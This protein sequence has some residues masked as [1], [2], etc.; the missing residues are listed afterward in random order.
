MQFDPPLR[1]A[2]LGGYSDEKWTRRRVLTLVF[3]LELIM[4]VILERPRSQVIVVLS[5][6]MRKRIAGWCIAVRSSEKTATAPKDVA[7]KQKKLDFRLC[8]TYGFKK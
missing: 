3:D 8:K 7:K 6:K 1:R 5:S 4:G 2:A